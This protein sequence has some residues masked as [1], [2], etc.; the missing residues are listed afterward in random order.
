MAT[1]AERFRITVTIGRPHRTRGPGS[2]SFLG[3]AAPVSIRPATTVSMARMRPASTNNQS[4]CGRRNE[5]FTR[6]GY[7]TLHGL[8]HELLWWDCLQPV[9][10]EHIER[11]AAPG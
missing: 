9:P 4:Q 1:V 2:R 5:V 8:D 10:S 3:S 6:Q 7:L 11:P